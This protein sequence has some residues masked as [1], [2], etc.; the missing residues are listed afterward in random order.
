M[1]N[2]RFPFP[3]ETVVL[4]CVKTRHNPHQAQNP[5]AAGT[6]PET[7]RRFPTGFA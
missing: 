1:S 3:F 2:V 4:F 6:R 7:E 5:E